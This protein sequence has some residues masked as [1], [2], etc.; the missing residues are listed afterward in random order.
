[1]EAFWGMLKSEMYY[2]RKF[3]TYEELRYV[4]LDLD[5]IF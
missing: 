1:M 2:L 4:P 3:Y 5:Y